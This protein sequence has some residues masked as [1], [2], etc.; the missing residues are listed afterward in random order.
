MRLT[1]Q[2][3]RRSRS[4]L[5]L[6]AYSP[7]SSS[8]RII[9][10]TLVSF[11]P[12]PPIHFCS[13]MRRP[14]SRR[15]KITHCSI[16]VRNVRPALKLPS[17]SRWLLRSKD[18]SLLSSSVMHSRYRVLVRQ[19]MKEL[20]LERWSRKFLLMR[21]LEVSMVRFVISISCDLREVTRV[22]T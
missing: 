11:P 16:R 12:R 8:P 20:R 22:L 3:T 7:F 10:K 4:R 17:S 19:R 1:R 18:P 9:R 5:D 15:F 14:R 6:F 21:M 2:K 13:N